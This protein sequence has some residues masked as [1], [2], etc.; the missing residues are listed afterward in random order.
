MDKLGTAR[1]ELHRLLEDPELSS[2]PI[3]VVSN[4]IDLEPHITEQELIR[5]ED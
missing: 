3:L 5:G 4:K 2:T 1:A